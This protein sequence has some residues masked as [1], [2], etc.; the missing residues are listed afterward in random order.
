[1]KKGAKEATHDDFVAE[2]TEDKCAI[3]VVNI[4]YDTDE[5]PVRHCVKRFILKWCPDSKLKA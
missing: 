1:M 3:A 2:F 5:V 4:K